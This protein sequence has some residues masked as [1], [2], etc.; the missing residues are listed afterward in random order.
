[1]CLCD[2]AIQAVFRSVVLA[3]FL[4]ASLA[5]WGFARVQDHQKVEGFLRRS[6]RARFCSKNLP[7]FSDICLRA[8]QNVFRKVLHN[9]Q[10]LLHQLLPPVSA[11]SHSYSLRKRAHNR[12]LPDRLS[13]L[14]DCNFIIRMLFYQSSWHLSA[15]IFSFTVNDV[16]NCGFVCSNVVY[17]L[18]QCCNCGLPVINKRICYVML[19]LIIITRH[20][21]STS[22]YSLTFRLHV[23]LP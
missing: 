10:H 23:M 18:L 17:I 19:W 9:P 22:M 4:H 11:S 20:R 16:N 13:R 5:W 1:M 8:D 15:F 14:V 21:A 2:T 3:R 7:N 6:T 12:Q